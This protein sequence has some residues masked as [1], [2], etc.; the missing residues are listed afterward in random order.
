MDINKNT[1]MPVYGR[2]LLIKRIEQKTIGAACG[3]N[4]WSR[5]TRSVWV[6]RYYSVANQSSEGKNLL[7][8]EPHITQPPQSQW[9]SK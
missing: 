6:G 5:P 3:E 9:S 2:G 7:Q 4:C 1:Y 8:H